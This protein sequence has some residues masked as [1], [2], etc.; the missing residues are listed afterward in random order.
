MGCGASESTVKST[1]I[2]NKELAGSKITK[3]DLKNSKRVFVQPD[4]F[5]LYDE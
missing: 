1:Q 5:L 2:V 3:G 4:M